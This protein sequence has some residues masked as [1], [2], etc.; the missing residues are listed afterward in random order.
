[1][2]IIIKII[3]FFLCFTFLVVIEELFQFLM[4]RFLKMRVD[5]FY[6]LFDH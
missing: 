2:D 6:I 4:A 3:Q 1:M 5:M